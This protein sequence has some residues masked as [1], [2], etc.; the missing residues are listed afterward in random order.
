M[1]NDIGAICSNVKK[2]SGVF[3]SRTETACYTK[4]FEGEG[5]ATLLQK[6]NEV[7][8]PAQAGDK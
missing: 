4:G 8:K 2:L 1:K 7:Q 5:F 3:E 6:G